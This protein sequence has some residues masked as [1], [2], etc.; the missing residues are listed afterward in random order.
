MSRLVPWLCCLLLAAPWAAR[1]QLPGG[2]WA[3]AW[4]DE[5]DGTNLDSTKWSVTTGARRDAQNAAAAVS[6]TNGALVIRTYTE[7]GVHKTG[8]VGSSG[9]FTDAFGYWEAREIGRAHV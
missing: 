5:F 4:S 9:K 7:S 3:L 2:S 6:V 8:F 1:A